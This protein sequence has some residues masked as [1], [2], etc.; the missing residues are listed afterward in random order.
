MGLRRKLTSDSQGQ[1]QRRQLGLSAPTAGAAR[2]PGARQAGEGLGMG[3]AGG[4]FTLGR[5]TPLS[6][7][8]MME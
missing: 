6:W 3:G 4:R 1:K 8:T 7:W 2:H 5:E